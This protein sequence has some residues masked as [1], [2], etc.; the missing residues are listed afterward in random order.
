MRSGF[1]VRPYRGPLRP[2]LSPV[3]RGRGLWR[4]LRQLLPVLLC[5]LLAGLGP[6]AD[7]VPQAQAGKPRCRLERVDASQL[8]KSGQLRVLGSITEVE[9]TLAETQSAKEFRL[10]VSGKVAAR[11][12]KAEPFERSGQEMF[13]V[14]A[15]EISALYAPSVDQIKEALHEF[16]EALPRTKVKLILFGADLE[17]SPGFL[18]PGAALQQIDELNPDDQGEVQLLNAL[19]SG[20]SA[21]NKVQ[22]G[23]DKSGNPLPTPRKVMVVLSD[24]LNQLMDRKTF[25]RTGDLLRQNGVPL[26]PVAF[27]PRDDRGPL[28]NLG[29]L[30][31]RSSGT[32]RWAPKAENLKEQFVN[33]AEELKKTSVISFS[34]KKLSRETLQTAS[35]VLQ[36]GELKSVPFTMSGLPPPPSSS[37]WKWVLGI[38]GTLVGLWGLA[39]GALWVLRRRSAQLGLGPVPGQPGQ[40]GQPLGGQ[41]TGGYPAAGQLGTLPPGAAGPG[42]YATLPIGTPAPLAAGAAPPVV[43][44]MVPGGRV[45]T[46]TLIGIGALGGQRVK[47]DAS[48]VIGKAA[49]PP[50]GLPI[51]SDPSVAASHCELRR[52]GAGYLLTDYNSP[53]GSFVNERRVQGMVRLADGDLIRLGEGTQFKFRLDD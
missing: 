17:P 39:Q 24:G 12:E 25:R 34:S 7:L 35:L 43:Y 48:L 51:T 36:C 18:A 46:A 30:A 41:A 4:G 6:V 29:E 45:Y 1:V 31:K 23:K 19:S 13:L 44:P 21:L 22:P 28:L 14:L 16:L 33:L 15:V 49:T 53:G 10:L 5:W 32:F 37:W 27:S 2:W 8:D 47:V 52:D 26:F 38:L 9:G 3:W 40:P 11:G 50:M 42:G 20:L